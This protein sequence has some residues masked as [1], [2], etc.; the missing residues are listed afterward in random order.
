MKIELAELVKSAELGIFDW[1][2]TISD[3]LDAVH[4]ANNKTLQ[5]FSAQPISLEKFGRNFGPINDAY[6]NL[7]ITPPLKEINKIFKTYFKEESPK[8]IPKAKETLE[9]LHKRIKLAIISAHPIEFLIREAIDYGI[10]YLFD[11]VDGDIMDKGAAIS[12]LIQYS[13][14][15]PE[16]AFYVGDTTYDI[17]AAKAAGVISIAVLNDG[18]AYH[19]REQLE[20]ANPDFILEDI[21]ELEAILN[22]K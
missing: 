14:L 13:D 12:M 8:I 5:H 22:L 7:G 17:L 19:S 1:S 3:D 6:R 4:N 9:R 21:S 11:F 20:S 10:F 18:K 2:G 16:K 15:I